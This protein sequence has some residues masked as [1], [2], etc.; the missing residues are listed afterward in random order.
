LRM[1]IAVLVL[2]VYCVWCVAYAVAVSVGAV[3]VAPVAALFAVIPAEAAAKC[4]MLSTKL[5]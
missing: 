3:V 5:L 4:T 1:Q 2:N